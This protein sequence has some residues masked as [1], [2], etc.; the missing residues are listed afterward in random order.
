MRRMRIVLPILILG[1]I[2]IVGLLLTNPSQAQ[3]LSNT[4]HPLDTVE[5]LVMPLVDVPAL[6]AED[7]VRAPRVLHHGLPSLSPWM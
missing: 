3:N 1:F 5:T 7:E 2:L 6:L 4:P